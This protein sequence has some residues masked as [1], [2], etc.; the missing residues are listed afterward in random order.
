VKFLGF[1]EHVHPSFVAGQIFVILDDSEHFAGRI[2]KGGGF[3][4]T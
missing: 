2:P 4:E 1:L 3:D